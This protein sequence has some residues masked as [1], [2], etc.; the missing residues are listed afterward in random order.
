MKVWYNSATIALNAGI[1]LYVMLAGSL[2]ILSRWYTVAELLPW[3]LLLGQ[4][5]DRF[6]RELQQLPSFLALMVLPSGIFA[7]WRL[8][9]LAKP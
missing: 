6:L 1:F 2:I 3:N 5:V 4:V 8:R 9:E 7:V